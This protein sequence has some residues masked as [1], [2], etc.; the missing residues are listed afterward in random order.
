MLSYP[1]E[2]LKE[3]VELLR[4]LRPEV[5]EPGQGKMQP[6]FAMI[7]PPSLP[8]TPA[9]MIFYDG[10]EEEAKKI[11][12]PLYDLEPINTMGG[13]MPYTAVTGIFK[14]MEMKGFDRW[15]SSS[16]HLTYPIDTEVLLAGIDKFLE[17]VKHHGDAFKHSSFIVDL[18]DYR[19][20]ASVPT[21]T[22]AYANR[23]D[24]AVVVPDFRWDDAKLD[25][26]ARRETTGIAAF[27][28]EMLKDKDKRTRVQHDGEREFESFYPN[29]SSGTEKI[30]SVYGSNLPRLRD[31]KAKYDPDMMWNKWFSLTVYMSG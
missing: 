25:Q 27:M 31:L 1:M 21:D 13:M 7:A 19:K 22:T 4:R 15:A 10:P 29:V 26:T 8:H 30:E 12:K 14:M 2:K 5:V 6:M 17:R 16:L 9:F 11:A 23:Y 28:K 18:R 3:C 20:V 24:A